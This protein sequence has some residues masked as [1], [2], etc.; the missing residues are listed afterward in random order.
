MK[1][2]TRGIPASLGNCLL[3]H[4]ERQR[5]DIALA[6]RQHAAYEAALREIGAHVLALPPLDELP[7]S[8]FVEDTAI[9]T[10]EVAVIGRAGAPER[11]P[12]NGAMA[13]VLAPHRALDFIEAPAV[14]DG[15][16]VL[17]LGKRVLV[18]IS[19]RTNHDAV[20]QLG[21]LLEP[22]GYTV[23]PV[24]VRHCLHLKSA[25]TA[26]AADTVLYNPEWVDAEL[27]P[28][29]Q[30]IA[31]AA[32]ESFAANVVAI[33]GQ[34]LV[35][36]AFPGTRDTIE[37]AGFRTHALDVSEL[38]KAEGALTCCSILMA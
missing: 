5:I 4:L 38:Q 15:G 14:I 36:A 32:G 6:K 12:E 20:A 24:P 34:V 30:K 37:R 2:I 31:V 35:S 10:A 29:R 23:S 27:L 25:V 22:H 21:V 19:G 33:N 8:V 3:T 9:V 26:L 13:Q 1:A 16:D 7:D 11:R 18:G 17:Q 28:A